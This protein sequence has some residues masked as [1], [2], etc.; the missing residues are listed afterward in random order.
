[1]L[2]KSK[3]KRS[4]EESLNSENNLMFITEDGFIPYEIE[5]CELIVNDDDRITLE[6]DIDTTEI[7]QQLQNALNQLIEV[8]TKIVPLVKNSL[9][10]FQEIEIYSLV[11]NIQEIVT[12][13]FDGQKKAKTNYEK[14]LDYEYLYCDLTDLSPINEYF[15]AYWLFMW[16]EKRAS[17]PT[18]S[19]V[20]GDIPKDK[21]LKYLD[22]RF[23]IKHLKEGSTKRDYFYQLY[24]QVK[25]YLVHY[26]QIEKYEQEELFTYEI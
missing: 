3:N 19:I 10:N 22:T 1:M 25:P 16:F 24:L 9:D 4:V 26:F 17:I 13:Q 21:I 23:S 11:E 12:N 5:E 6:G 15:R 14:I 2:T 7:V 20:F 18:P 8:K